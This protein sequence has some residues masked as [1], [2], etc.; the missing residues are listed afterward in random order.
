MLAGFYLVCAS[1]CRAPVGGAGAPLNGQEAQTAGSG[2]APTK[3]IARIKAVPQNIDENG[4]IIFTDETFK[5]YLQVFI[6]KKGLDD[7][8][9]VVEAARTEEMS[10]TPRAGFEA[11]SDLAGIEHFSNLKEL[12]IIGQDIMHLNLACNNRLTQLWLQRSNRLADVV[13]PSEPERLLGVHIIACPLLKAIDFSGARALETLH[14]DSCPRYDGPLNLTGM[15]R[16]KN[17]TL[18]A[19]AVPYINISKN[20][21]LARLVLQN[22][23]EILKVRLSRRQNAERQKSLGLSNWIY[24]NQPILWA[25]ALP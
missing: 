5:N 25:P 1:S 24:D 8:I 6:F 14:L 4:N 12:N 23:L 10:L 22:N 18:R 17:L 7:E 11:I 16:L 9:S 19:T 20:S 3:K 15:A 2:V 21:R 13:L